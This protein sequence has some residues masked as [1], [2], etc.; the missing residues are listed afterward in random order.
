MAP[1]L[2]YV[3]ATYLMT[4]QLGSGGVGPVITSALRIG[5][6]SALTGNFAIVSIAVGNAQANGLLP[7]E[8]VRYY[9]LLVKSRRLRIADHSHTDYVGLVSAHNHTNTCMRFYVLRSLS[10]LCYYTCTLLLCVCYYH[11][12]SND[13]ILTSVRKPDVKM[14]IV[15]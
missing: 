7:N 6:C 2:Q 5:Y 9:N 1:F 3:V 10:C 13:I 11:F 15:S 14:L 8:N 4:S 12:L